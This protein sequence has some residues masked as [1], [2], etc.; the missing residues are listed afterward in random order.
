VRGSV[1]FLLSSA[2]SYPVCHVI[3]RSPESAVPLALAVGAASLLNDLDHGAS[4]GAGL[5]RLRWLSGLVQATVGHRSGYSHSITAT[6]VWAALWATVAGAL[7]SPAGEEPTLRA[8]G[9]VFAVILSGGLLHVFGD[10]LPIGSK[11][12]VPALWPFSRRLY[13]LRLSGRRPRYRV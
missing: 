13:K 11:A 3:T 7:V 12:G 8:A 6:V 1:H 5:L 9:V 4:L 2:L 10:W